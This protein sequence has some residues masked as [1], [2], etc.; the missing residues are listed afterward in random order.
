MTT[1]KDLDLTNYSVERQHEILAEQN[2]IEYITDMQL[3]SV[4]AALN[5]ISAHWYDCGGF[6]VIITCHAAHRIDEA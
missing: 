3:R 2:L 5:G 4:A 6:N 1:T